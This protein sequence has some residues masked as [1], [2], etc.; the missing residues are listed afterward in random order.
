M[1]AVARSAARHAGARCT[2]E[3]VLIRLAWCD[4]MSADAG[5]V[6]LGGAA[7]AGGVVERGQDAETAPIR[8][9]VRD[10]VDRPVLV[11]DLREVQRSLRAHRP[12]PSSA[13]ARCH[14]SS[15][16]PPAPVESR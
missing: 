12:L 6:G 11:D 5:V 2:I 8:H 10:K 16:R 14:P 9:L 4:V 13:S 7:F 15:R 1:R 3:A